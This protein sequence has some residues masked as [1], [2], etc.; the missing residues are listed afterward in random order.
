MK[1][2]ECGSGE[3]EFSYTHG[4]WVCNI[5]NTE[6]GC[7]Y[8]KDPPL[9]D[10]IPWEPDINL[11]LDIEAQLPDELAKYIKEHPEFQEILDWK[12][13]RPVITSEKAVVT[14]NL[15]LTVGDEDKSGWT[16]LR[17]EN[18]SGLFYD[19]WE[20]PGKTRYI[21]TIPRTDS[22]GKDV[23]KTSLLEEAN[24]KFDEIKKERDQ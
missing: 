14:Q 7:G 23:L 20:S 18:L 4:K 11:L 21:V 12:K 19:I 13:N 2:P 6:L 9:Y 16:L 17:R 15:R 22:S 10:N 5:D 24:N 8:S 3:L 1:C